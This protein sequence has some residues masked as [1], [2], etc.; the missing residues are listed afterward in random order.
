MALPCETNLL[1][2]KRLFA[3]Q[4]VS[5]QWLRPHFRPVSGAVVV[6]VVDVRSELL[7]YHF[8]K[9]TASSQLSEL[10]SCDRPPLICHVQPWDKHKSDCISLDEFHIT[11]EEPLTLTRILCSGCSHLH[12]HSELDDWEALHASI[13]HTS[14]TFL[15]EIKNQLTKNLHHFLPSHFCQC[16]YCVLVVFLPSYKTSPLAQKVPLH[17]PMGQNGVGFYPRRSHSVILTSWPQSHNSA[18]LFPLLMDCNS[19]FFCFL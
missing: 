15:L 19:K 16:A 10:Q 6:V 14:L 17:V 13:K 2:S 9:A 12:D 18:V 7:V 4:W 1:A 3:S 11:A 5:S 8:L